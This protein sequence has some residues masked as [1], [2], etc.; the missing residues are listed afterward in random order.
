MN[1]VILPRVR[2]RFAHVYYLHNRGKKSVFFGLLFL[3]V[4]LF[5]GG[6]LVGMYFED[7]AI[8]SE[9]EAG[10]VA[11]KKQADLTERE[12]QAAA[13]MLTTKVGMLQ[14]HLSHIDA[15]ANMLVDRAGIDAEEFSFDSTLA[16]GGP[17]TSFV[18]DGQAYIEQVDIKMDTVLER[19]DT[20]LEE[21]EYQLRVLA[22]LLINKKLAHEAHPRGWPVVHGWISSYFGKRKSPFTGAVEMH[23]GIDFAGKPGSDVVAVAGGIV[24][25]AAEDGS[26]GYMVEIDHGNGYMTRYAHNEVVLVQVGE[27]ILRGQVIAKLGSTGRSTGPHVHFEVLKDGV[28]INPIAFIK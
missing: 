14:A 10:I 12:S 18:H 16:M 9:W 22:D 5:S 27:A 19:L 13:D 2:T 26:Y 3:S 1:I 23:R 8:L 20:K 6:Y 4:T 11:Q 17:H 25:Q 21:R 24:T 7:K 28:R 15:L